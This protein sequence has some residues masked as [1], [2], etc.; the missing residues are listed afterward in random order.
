ML[1]APS[2]HSKA[3]AARHERLLPWIA[4]ERGLRA[5]L[6]V[7][8]GAIL[9]SHPH[10]NWAAEVRR[11]ATDAGLNPSGNVVR[12][13][14]EAVRKIPARETTV[15]G[16]IALAYG[17]L[18]AA[19]SYGLARRR[20]WGEWLTLVATAILI[21]PEVWELIRDVTLLKVGALIVNLLVVAYLYWQLR[22]SGRRPARAEGV[23]AA[24]A[25]GTAKT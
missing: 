24:D 21:V 10:T 9:I 2:A 23:G 18:E 19:E 16:V 20:R 7:T 4:A 11:L 15:F 1:E 14:L 5:A 13:I 3:P 25:A 17:A 12:R 22:R 8:L 6:L